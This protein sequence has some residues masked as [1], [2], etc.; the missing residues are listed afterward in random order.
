MKLIQGIDFYK[1]ISS[2]AVSEEYDNY[3]G[4]SLVIEASGLSGHDISIEGKI[5]KSIDEWTKL[6]IVDLATMGIVTSIISDGLYALSVDGI[7]CIRA[8]NKGANGEISLIGRI[9]DTPIN[10]ASVGGGGGGT[11][12]KDGKDGK[13]GSMWYT[14]TAITGESTTPTAF[15]TGISKVNV[16]DLYLNTDTGNVYKCVTGGSE[17]NA[18]WTYITCIMGPAGEAG[19]V[20]QVAR[21]EIAELD[22]R[23]TE[24]ED[25][26]K[27]GLDLDGGTAGSA[28]DYDIDGGT[29]TSDY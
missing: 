5:L 14:G 23:V 25:I 6:A 4:S 21:D 7:R 1:G 11:P 20:D 10:F 8:N 29:A 19:T 12:G 16:G 2:P 27:N 17:T 3:Y 15:N 9:T 13:D 24:L 22:K 26:L 28:S 18:L